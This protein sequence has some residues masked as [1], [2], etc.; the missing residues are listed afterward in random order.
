[1][2]IMIMRCADDIDAGDH[3]YGGIYVGD[4]GYDGIDVGD[5]G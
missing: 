2:P 5:D 3:G 4:N 1:M